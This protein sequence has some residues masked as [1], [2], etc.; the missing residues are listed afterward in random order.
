MKTL[1]DGKDHTLPFNTTNIPLS[2]L[3]VGDIIGVEKAWEEADVMLLYKVVRINK[4]TVSVK[5]C[6]ETGET[7][8]YDNKECKEKLTIWP[9]RQF[10]RLNYL[11]N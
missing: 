8:L 9:N 2:E 5:D 10:N 4:K 6:D 3:K 7:Y 1:I 11:E